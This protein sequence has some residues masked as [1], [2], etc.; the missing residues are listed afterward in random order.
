MWSSSQLELASLGVGLIGLIAAVLALVHLG[1]STRRREEQARVLEGRATAA[2]MG[3]ELAS[4]QAQV[5]THRFTLLFAASPVGLA[6]L[7]GHGHIARA[8]PALGGLLGRPAEELVD[9][10][11]AAVLAPDDPAPL[12]A[13]LAAAGEGW[14]SDELH[15]P[16]RGEPSWARVHLSVVPQD[17]VAAL[18]QVEDV[19][20]LHQARDR[21]EHLATHD[22]LTDLP[23]CLTF[24]SRATQALRQASRTGVYVGCL[25]VDLDHFRIVNDSLGHAA[26][27][28]VL[29][30]V[31]DRLV[32]TL[33]PGD[34][35]AR[36][37]GD[38]FCLLLVGLEH[39]SE[40]ALVAQRVVAALASVVEVDGGPV[41]TSASVGVAVARPGDKAT[42]ETL[43][44]DAD[45]ALDR[46]KAGGRGRHVV[47][48][49]A[50]AG[51]GEPILLRD[52]PPVAAAPP[53]CA[54][55]RSAA[56]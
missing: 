31:A 5:A 17:T 3:E 39:Q 19:T 56:G 16:S 38:E 34:T 2:T 45:T 50:M 28:R 26:G 47:F 21:L 25:V 44:R 32:Q 41:N 52:E 6:L 15:L 30:A 9:L 40:A 51:G 54:P 14:T 23:S 49:E 8:N 11:L 1:G 33:R 37:G 46:A 20:E 22:L 48:D 12:R 29:V 24:H 43:I 10:E 36:M 27:D 53:L 7:D 35:V 13:G 55:S 42:S 18:V 4:H